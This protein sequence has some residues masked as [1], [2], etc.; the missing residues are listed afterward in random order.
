LPDGRSEAYGAALSALAESRSGGVDAIL[1]VGEA[2]G[3]DRGAAE[4]LVEACWLRYRD[5]LCRE[6][7]GDPELAVFEA[8]VAPV[9]ARGL[10]ALLSGLAA[11]REAWFSPQGNVSP[12]L[13]VEVL[14]GS[15]ARAEAG[16]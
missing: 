15:L 8:P 1:R 10:D 14:L 12:R 13:T 7:G 5:L 16:P 9:V 6:A 3:R 11:C 2:L 4:T